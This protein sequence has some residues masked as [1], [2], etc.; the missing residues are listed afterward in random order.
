MA[1]PVKVGAF[2]PIVEPQMAG[3]TPRWSDLKAM[4]RTAEDVGLD[5]IWIPDHLHFDFPGVKES[6]YEC[7]TMLSALAAVTERVEIGTLVVCT[8]FR[9]PAVFA[10]MVNT[11]EEISGGRLILGLGAGY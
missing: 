6:T 7:V 4:A 2:L 9:N 5:S 10:A 1:R 11:I 3:E 8:G